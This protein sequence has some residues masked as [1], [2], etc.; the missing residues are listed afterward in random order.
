M[1]NTTQFPAQTSDQWVSKLYLYGLIVLP[2][3]CI[4]QY[5]RAWEGEKLKSILQAVVRPP[6]LSVCSTSR[7]DIG[8]TLQHSTLLYC[9]DSYSTELC[10]LHWLMSP[11]L[12]AASLSRSAA[13][14][15]QHV[16]SLLHYPHQ[17]EAEDTH[18]I[19]PHFDEQIRR[20]HRV[21]NH[22]IRVDRSVKLAKYL[23]TGLSAIL[24]AESL[25]YFSNE[26]RSQSSSN[27]SRL[28][29]KV[30]HWCSDQRVLGPALSFALWFVN[31][32]L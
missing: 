8:K 5:W 20:S 28:I 13:C 19:T 18:V 9:T 11:S 16:E 22:Q 17:V 24:L 27:W 2:L 25:E 15:T 32:S 23:T 14:V 10:Q 29:L 26:V 21:R 30:W 6:Y 1:W 31:L 7:Y 12:L 3:S 4:Y